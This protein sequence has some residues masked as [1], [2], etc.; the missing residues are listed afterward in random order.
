MSLA[1]L[2]LL[3][4]NKPMSEIELFSLSMQ[5]RIHYKFSRYAISEKVIML[6]AWNPPKKGGY[7]LSF[8]A[9][10]SEEVIMS[11]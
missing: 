7:R 10:F 2:Y 9:V 6:R 5:H 8:T 1:D 4:K 11:F 3:M